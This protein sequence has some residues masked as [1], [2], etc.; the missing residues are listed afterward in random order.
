MENSEIE[1]RKEKLLAYFKGRYDILQYLVLTIIILLGTFIR[2]QPL[3]KLIDTTTGKY[4]SIE[5]DSTLFLRYA[6][7]I[8]EHGRLFAHDIMRYYPLGNDVS[9][10]VFSSY[11]VAYLWKFIHIFIPS[12]SIEYVNNLY[13]VIAMAIMTIFLFLLVRRL[14][15]WRVGLLSALLITV[16]PGFLFRSLGG[17]SDHDM[18]GAMFIILAFY[19]YIIGFQSKKLKSITIFGTITAIVVALAYLTGGSIQFFYFTIVAFNLFEILIGKFTKK[20]LLLFGSFITVLT[21]FLLSIDRITI[22]ALLT[23]LSTFPLY[24]LFL[25]GILYHY[26]FNKEAK[27]YY[28]IKKYEGKLNKV[29]ANILAIITTLIL[30]LSFM[31]IFYGYGTLQN[32][33]HSIYLQLFQSF[34]A[35]RW[36]LT[37]AENRSVVIKDW[38]GQY[39]KF[40]VFTAITGSIFIFYEAVKYLKKARNLTIAYIIFTLGYFYSKYYDSGYFAAS[41]TN[42]RL[43]FLGSAIFMI[44][45]FTYYYFNAYKNDND[46]YNNIQKIDKKH[47]IILFWFIIMSFIATTAIRFLFELSLVLVIVSSFFMIY[48]FDLFMNRKESYL[49]YTGII[50]LALVLFSPFSFAKGIVIDQYNQVYDAARFSGPGYNQQWQQAGKWVRDNT[51]KDA[52]FAHWWD[53]GY[54]VQSGFERATVTDGGNFIGWWNYLMGRYVLTAQTKEEPLKFLK[55]H[56]V[57]YLL[58][59]TDEI[60]KYPAYSSIGSDAN[61]DRNSYIPTFGLDDKLTQKTR[62]KTIIYYTGSFGLDEDLNYNG[63]ILPKGASGIAGVMLPLTNDANGQIS[64]IGQPIAIAGYNNERINLKMSC[65]YVDK[66]YMFKDYDIDACIRVMPVFNDNNQIN[67]IGSALY[68]SRKVEHSLVGRLYIL[69]QNSKYY[70][71]VYDDTTKGIP[72]GYYQ[73]RLIGP[74][75]IWKINYPQDLKINDEEINYFT[76]TDYPDTALTK[77]I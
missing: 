20:D 69:N 43:L 35:T 44:G 40:L 58:I 38:I 46:E 66:L 23:S 61:S 27:Y 50:L 48:I 41:S 32:I 2:I 59:V 52:V 15:D 76:R 67:P 25:C 72:L 70:Q 30:S 4:I 10:G 74:H 62:D 45:Y 77:P 11:F 54:W 63:K 8:A 7:Y 64:G 21:F 51:P 9:I 31:L 71:L 26:L 39:G 12:I 5:L 13:P 14:F 65:L 68:L 1:K 55:L 18:L 28:I 22:G 17:S 37:V 75:R 34:S 57:S 42:A 47:T 49:K 19:F 33:F 60:G 36:V 6:Q 73:G 53:Y 24:F 29:P 3:S 56:N 16:S